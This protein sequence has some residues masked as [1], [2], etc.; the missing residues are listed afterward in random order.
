M[1]SIRITS[2]NS[3]GIATHHRLAEID[4]Y[5]QDYRPEVLC[6][7]ETFL[8]PTIKVNIPGYRSVRKDRPTH[9]GGVIIFIKNDIQCFE[10]KHSRVFK[11]IEV[12]SV[13]L[14]ILVNG[15]VS[16][17]VLSNVYMPRANRFLRPDI[18]NL[19]KINNHI[20]AG[21]FN[22]IHSNWSEGI[23][24][25]AG[26]L[27]V[28]ILPFNNNI[29]CAPDSHTHT[30]HNGSCSTIDFLITNSLLYN[31]DIEI[32]NGLCSDHL[33]VR[34]SIGASAV[35]AAKKTVY[36]YD[37]A[38]WVS[39]EH[40]MQ[41]L[42]E[43]DLVSPADIDNALVVFISQIKMAFDDSVPKRVIHSNNDSYL[44]AE[45]LS[46]IAKKNAVNRRLHNRNTTPLDKVQLK[47][48]R[49]RLAND[50]HSSVFRDRCTR[51]GKLIARMSR[52]KNEFWKLAKIARKKNNNNNCFGQ[53]SKGDRVFSNKS[54]IAN[55]FAEQFADA[56]TAFVVKNN[57]LDKRVDR[58]FNILLCENSTAPVGY[59][60]IDDLL[61]I[62]SNLRCSKAPGLDGVTNLMCKRLPFAALEHLL[63]I[64][65]SA[66]AIG[67]WPSSFKTAI[68]VPIHK[69]GKDVKKTE[70]YRPVSLLSS[71][72]KLMERLLKAKIEAETT[73]LN[74]L[75]SQQFGFRAHRSSVQQ[76]TNLSASIKSNKRNKKSTGVLLLD[77]AKAFDSVW[78]AGLAHRLAKLGYERH[79]VKMIASFCTNRFFMVRV[80]GV[81][82]K[83]KPIPA[84]V[85]Q[86]SCLSPGLYNI[87]TSF[88]RCNEELLTFA[89]DT[90]V[91]VTGLNGN[92]IVKRIERAFSSLN[93]KFDKWHICINAN[94]TEFLFVPPDR[95]RI[96]VP[97]RSP[98]LNGVLIESATS[99]RYLG[100]LFN[101]NGLFSAHFKQM[102][103]KANAT[104]C[105]LYSLFK[106]DK[107]PMAHRVSLVKAVLYPVVFHSMPAWSEMSA[108][109]VKQLASSF[110]RCARQ[111]LGLTWRHPT[112]DLYTKL[113]YAPI[114]EHIDS[115][116]DRLYQRIMQ[117]NDPDLNNLAEKMAHA[118]PNDINTILP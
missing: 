41:Q 26:R 39:Y 78:H 1:D 63:C 15:V 64:F 72:S 54:D 50:I 75:P 95:K 10:F 73:R 67:Y 96:R 117:H 90:A 42:P 61:V 102:K 27:L 31:D 101:N 85:P 24:N 6:V 104:I 46:L 51:W 4:K 91:V 40:L 112:S 23:E 114:K 113:N 3:R 62:V 8:N 43:L 13:Q 79:I 65:N 48:R 36:D 74:I 83:R 66:Y 11:C 35:C 34:F 70:S 22:A 28:D 58:E 116:K 71:L 5:L 111:I 81:H 109:Q 93:N 30:H 2:Y 68:V 16:N 33:P 86:G 118:W 59:F 21:D 20:I 84:G 92:A 7:Q 60:D 80:N 89:D 47:H 25:V 55:A 76:A 18:K 108:T 105:G 52:S 45:S 57:S 94:K 103:A 56:H 99:I 98:T 77:V 38:D 88:A 110:Q 29:L 12:I 106:G 82:S 9:G 115:A 32:E 37:R 100:V 97:S 69:R 87:Y 19:L 49:I 107:L 44:S 14:A 17:I 53:M